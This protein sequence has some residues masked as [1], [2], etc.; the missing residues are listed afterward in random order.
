MFNVANG[1]LLDQ[2]AQ[3]VAELGFEGVHL[4]VDDQ[5]QDDFL[6]VRFQAA[7]GEV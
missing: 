3:A 7:L 1:D 6:E 2:L 4:F 5:V